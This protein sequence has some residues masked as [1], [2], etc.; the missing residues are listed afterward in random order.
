[1]LIEKSNIGKDCSFTDYPFLVFVA[2]I[3]TP[4]ATIPLACFLVP[5]I[6]VAKS[7]QLDASENFSDT[8]SCQSKQVSG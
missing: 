6:A 5:T 3:I 2:H 8:Y 7:P 1:M 4:L